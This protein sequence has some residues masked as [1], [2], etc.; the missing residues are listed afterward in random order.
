MSGTTCLLTMA[1][2]I[3]VMLHLYWS[4]SDF[5]WKSVFTLQ[6]FVCEAILALFCL[7]VLNKGLNSF[8]VVLF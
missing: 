6:R 4:E 1:T 3:A 2:V 5:A 7:H 8:H